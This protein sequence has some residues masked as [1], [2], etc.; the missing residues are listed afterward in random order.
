M[1]D[2]S[3]G[4]GRIVHIGG[5]ADERCMKGVVVSGYIC[6]KY[7]STDHKMFFEVGYARCMTQP[8]RILFSRSILLGARDMSEAKVFQTA[9]CRVLSDT[10]AL[11][12]AC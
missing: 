4:I 8:Q 1:D 9:N 12:R 3:S 11:T 6:K 5:C 7:N 2:L 10:L